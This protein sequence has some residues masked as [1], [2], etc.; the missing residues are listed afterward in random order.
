MSQAKR[1]SESADVNGDTASK[2]INSG[3]TASSAPTKQS[4]LL[5]WATS[6][7][8]VSA[9][10]AA[11]APSAASDA[12]TTTTDGDVDDKDTASNSLGDAKVLSTTTAIPEESSKPRPNILTNLS[13]DKQIVLQLEQDT[14]ETTWLRALQ[15]EFT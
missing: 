7:P 6:K 3:N 13:K 9:A 12:P 11:V 15:S 2:R 5:A 14:M 10:T 4:S 1:P 8:K